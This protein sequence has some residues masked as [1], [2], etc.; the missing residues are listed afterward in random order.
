[1]PL[2]STQDANDTGIMI[3]GG[4]AVA[5]SIPVVEAASGRGGATYHGESVVKVDVEGLAGGAAVVTW[6]V[7]F[8]KGRLPLLLW[9][10][11]DTISG[12]EV[13]HG[14]HLYHGSRGYCLVPAIHL[15]YF[16]GYF[17]YV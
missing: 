15:W 7:D 1:M 11:D 17:N 13:V 6:D 5:S 9:D 14:L 2:I 12:A 8:G 3:M 10:L 16:W 4:P